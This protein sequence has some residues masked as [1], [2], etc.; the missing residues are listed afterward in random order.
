MRRQSKYIALAW[1]IGCALGTVLLLTSCVSC[2]I[3][4]V[5]ENAGRY[6]YIDIRVQYRPNFDTVWTAMKPKQER[7]ITSS[8]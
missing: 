5:G 4:P 8:K 1:A 2:P 3:P 7:E 6:G